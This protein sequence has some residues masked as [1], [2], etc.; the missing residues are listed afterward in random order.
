MPTEVI[1]NPGQEFSNLAK[2]Q[3]LPSKGAEN[4]LSLRIHLGSLDF[5]EGKLDGAEQTKLADLIEIRHLSRA[6]GIEAQL[7]LNTDEDIDTALA[8]YQTSRRYYQRPVPP[9]PTLMPVRRPH[10]LSRYSEGLKLSIAS[11]ALAALSALVITDRVSTHSAAYEEFQSSRAELVRIGRILESVPEPEFTQ[12]KQ[13]AP[14]VFMR[15]ISAASELDDLDEWNTPQAFA[16]GMSFIMIPSLA[17]GMGV[18]SMASLRQS[19]QK[20]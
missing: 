7:S 10:I 15:Y 5:I 16:K 12:A 19:W 4:G 9:T 17:I 6:A 8:T 20:R 13:D 3:N 2:S 14:K 1:L 18:L 11:V